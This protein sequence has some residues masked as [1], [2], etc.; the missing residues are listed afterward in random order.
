MNKITVKHL[1]SAENKHINKP[2]IL[3][4][5]EVEVDAC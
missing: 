2:G 3:A 1:T 4:T 5:V